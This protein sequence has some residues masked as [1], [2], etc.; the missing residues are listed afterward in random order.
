MCDIMKKPLAKL[1][2]NLALVTLLIESLTISLGTNQLLA[3][4]VSKAIPVLLFNNG[5]PVWVKREISMAPQTRERFSTSDDV[6][7][8]I[9]E[10]MLLTQLAGASQSELGNGFSGLFPTGSQL[11]NV[12]VVN[13]QATIFLTF[14]AGYLANLNAVRLDFWAE[15]FMKF[16]DEMPGLHSI[17]P[18]AK[19]NEH[20]EYQPLSTFLPTPP[21]LVHKPQGKN[22]ENVPTSKPTRAGQRTAKGQPQPFGALSGASIFLS[23]GHGW[24]YEEDW[25]TQRSEVFNIIE[26]HSNAEAVFQ[27]LV[28]YLWN[29]GARVYTTRE[30]DMNSNM[31]IVDN[32]DEGYSEMGDWKA[33]NDKAS[34]KD[35][36]RYTTTVT[37]EATATATFTPNI[38]ED[39]YYAVYVWYSPTVSDDAISIDTK[40]TINHTGDST[41]WTQNQNRDGMTWKYVGTYY[42]QAGIHPQTGSVVIANDSQDSSDNLVIADAVRF[43]G[44]IGISG[45]PRWEESGLYYL[46][47][48]GNHT[49]EYYNTV[50]ALP[51]YATWEY[52]AW[53]AG[54]SIYVAWHTNASGGTGTESYAYSSAGA[55]GEFN[56]VAGSLELRD[57]IHDELLNDIRAEWNPEWVDRGKKTN[58]FGELNPNYN[59]EM[60]ST[61]IEIAFHDT[62][63]DANAIKSPNFRRLTARAVYQGIVNFYSQNMKGFYD[64][65]LLPEP[66]TNF[67]VLHNGSGSVTLA[68]EEPPFN[69]ED[70]LL[71]DAADGYR[72]YRSRNG[73]GFDNGTD[74]FEN[75]ITFHDLTPNQVYYFRVTATNFGGESFPTETLAVQVRN[76]SEKTPI[77][78]V[79]GFDR[80][81][82]F[83]NIMEENVAR[84]YLERMN[85]YDY[86]IAHAQAIHQSGD[87]AFDSSSN[88][89]IIDKQVALEDYEVVIW[90]LGEESTAD[91]TFDTTEQTLVTH[92][93]GT[94]GN[95]FVSGAEIGWEL[96]HPNST[97]IHFYNHQLKSQ[98]VADDSENYSAT[99]VPGTIFE[100]ISSLTFDDGT[101]IYDVDFPDQIAAANGSVIN[102]TYTAPGTGGAA[103]QYAGG[104][105]ERRLVMMAIP[106]ETIT[107]EKVRN[108]VMANILNFFGLT[109]DISLPEFNDTEVLI[110]T[111]GKLANLPTGIEV[112]TDINSQ[113]QTDS[114]LTQINDL[115]A[116]K[117]NH[118]Q[119]E[120]HPQNAQLRLTV[121]DIRYAVLPVRIKQ[122]NK[123]AQV[124]INPDASVNFVTSLGRDILAHPI[125]QK[126]SAFCEALALSAITE[127]VWHN[128]GILNAKLKESRIVARADIIAN[129]VND[130]E[131][132]GLFPSQ[133]SPSVR[134][135]F[136]DDNQQKWQQ[137]I[138]PFSAY[139]DALYAV[140]DAMNLQLTNHG[141]IFF[142]IADKHYHGIFDYLV[143]PSK[144]AD[145]PQNAPVIF[146]SIEKEDIT[147]GFLVTYPNGETQKLWLVTGANSE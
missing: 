54:T 35:L 38:P 47:F 82:R 124:T 96:A 44:G 117:N 23:P 39:G 75:S 86:I 21:P 66:P 81:D 34:Y 103:L 144:E 130:N 108:A 52:E 68:W 20:S 122:L 141:N 55:G 145:K 6:I 125:V 83:A 41:V 127:V 18:F 24:H 46:D 14:P 12:K 71:G 1:F 121:A 138:H 97:G 49:A 15:V 59:S 32:Q 91:H 94:G 45:Y 62:L 50:T 93:L 114:L 8:I 80:L 119:L 19:S 30:R 77:L 95:L 76:S 4:S 118:W 3:D 101:S 135:V 139:P 113:P 111:N 133:A 99:G 102:L 2:K 43:G 104:Y 105:P 48:M 74:V 16:I 106:F 67:R 100:N 72:V 25:K 87:F 143:H 5:M 7:A 128:N 26:D 98:F 88:E 9:L 73:K 13:G 57:A 17:L 28:Q 63:S 131:P 36:A 31:V 61:L 142:T 42:F 56:G 123:P 10:Q 22:V 137:L 147:E 126:I 65:T 109:T 51:T 40:I 146:T 107:E 37:G 29:A 90:I 112:T 58:F 140:Q 78:I 79:N 89:A 129:S 132:L 115:P 11:D 33:V 70:D 136:I 69:F 60:P 64:T 84:G 134:L 110:C 92:F 53:E 120:Q 27:N 85:T 116:L